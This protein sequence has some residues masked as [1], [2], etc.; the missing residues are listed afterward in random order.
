MILSDDTLRQT[1]SSSNDLPAA[2]LVTRI[3]VNRLR[4]EVR[5]NPGSISA[6]IAEL[7][8][9]IAK[10]PNAATELARA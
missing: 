7:K 3:L 4:M 5:A 9:F 8:A 10:N 6:K 1:I 2:S